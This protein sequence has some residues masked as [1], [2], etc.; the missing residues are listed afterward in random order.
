MVLADGMRTMASNY[1]L[2]IFLQIECLPL[3]RMSIKTYPDVP[4]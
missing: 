2:M 4:R 3:I 1:S